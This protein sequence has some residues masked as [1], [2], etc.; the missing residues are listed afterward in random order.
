MSSKPMHVNHQCGRLESFHA[1][2]LPNCPEERPSR[3]SAFKRWAVRLVSDQSMKRRYH[4]DRKLK[5]RLLGGSAFVRVQWF[6]ESE[7]PIVGWPMLTVIIEPD[8]MVTLVLIKPVFWETG[9]P[10]NI[11]SDECGFSFGEAAVDQ[12]LPRVN[13]EYNSGINLHSWWS[14]VSVDSAHAGR[15]RTDGT[16]KHPCMKLWTILNILIHDVFERCIK[17]WLWRRYSSIYFLC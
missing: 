17:H 3:F 14:L 7:W 8:P 9:C 2:A 15:C 16:L 12:M 11:F 5:P 6:G 10:G 13:C 1:W 4:C